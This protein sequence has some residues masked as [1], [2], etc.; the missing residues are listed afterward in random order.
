M[1]RKNVSKALALMLATVTCLSAC[2]NPDAGKN[3]EETSSKTTESVAVS[4]TATEVTEEAKPM[5]PLEGKPTFTVAIQE[6]AAVVSQFPDYNEVPWINA[7]EEA[8]GVTLKI[9]QYSTKAMNLMFASG[10]LPDIVLYHWDSY[11]GGIAKAVSDGLVLPITDYLDYAPDLKALM[12][13]SDS[14]R[15]ANTTPEGEIIGFPRVILDERLLKMNGVI[16]RKEFLDQVGMEAP[17]TLDEMYEVLKAFKDQLGIEAPLGVTSSQVLDTLLGEGVWTSAFGFAHGGEYVKDGEIR[18]GYYSDW[19]QYKEAVAFFKKLYDEKLLDNNYAVKPDTSANFM[20]GISGVGYFAGASGLNTLLVT[21][22][23]DPNFS[24]VP[25]PS[26]V[27][28]EGDIPMSGAMSGGMGSYYAVI[29]PACKDI[30]NAVKLLNYG[31]TEEGHMQDNFG[32]EGITYEMID[33]YPTFTEYV[34]NNPN[35]LTMQQALVPYVTAAQQGRGAVQDWRYYEQYAGLPEQQEALEI[36]RQ[37]DASKYEIERTV[38]VPADLL[39]EYKALNSD[40]NTYVTETVI[41]C[42]SGQIS[43]EDFEKDFIATLDKLNMKRMIEIRQ[44]AYDEWLTR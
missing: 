2:G 20:N 14:V 5:Y 13:S 8:T 22:K 30:E 23:D 25:I 31:Y 11:S 28:K 12:E 42:I 40:I 29:T 33:G 17:N 37:N 19:E 6:R 7:W 21:M 34:T 26:L 36:W 43:M 3:N 9:E 10:E 15:R 32:I 4:E 38:S 18:Y 16:V 44:K 35:G 24:F 39:N 27:A 41:K 1:K